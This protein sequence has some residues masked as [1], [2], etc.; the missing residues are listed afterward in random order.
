[1]G[2]ED[3]G[4]GFLVLHLQVRLGGVVA[5]ALLGDAQ[6]VDGRLSVDDPFGKLPARATR[7]G[8]A[9]AVAFIGPEVLP[10]PGRADDRAAVRGVAD[11]PVV[12]LFHADLAEGG[13]AVDGAFDM[14]FQPL[15]ILLE[16]FELGI[17]L[18]AVDVAGGRALL[19]GAEQQATAFLAHVPGCIGIAQHAHL[20]QSLFLA[21]EDIR[22]CLRDDVLVFDGDHGD[23][24]AQHLPGLLHEVAGGRDQ[25]LAGDL[26]LVSGHLPLPGRGATDGGDAGLAIDGGPAL[27]G[28]GGEGLGQIGGLHV[29]VI[30]V[31]DRAHQIVGVAQRPDLLHLLRCQLPDIDTNGLR[32]ACILQVFVH[33]FLRGREADVGNPPQADVLARLLLQLSVLANRVL[34]NLADG[35]G[36]VE[37]RQQ[38][39]SM[40]GGAGCQF[41]PLQQHHIGPALLRQVI[42]R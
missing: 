11:G 25:V 36:Q 26:P 12:D 32:H 5:V 13:H 24:Q 27:P 20:R 37:Q 22:M 38:S 7:C 30:R 40:P 39:G 31:L 16:Q 34:V 28:T 1:M 42:Q 8:D 29:T 14:G 10:V 17:R 19:V 4:V 33:A 9:K 41:V 21:G 2:D 23:L 15:Q 3:V 18:R 6:H 35:I